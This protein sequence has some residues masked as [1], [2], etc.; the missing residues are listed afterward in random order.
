MVSVLIRWTTAF[1][2]IAAPTLVLQNEPSHFHSQ[3][4]PSYFYSQSDPHPTLYQSKW[5]FR[6]FLQFIQHRLNCLIFTL[7]LSEYVILLNDDSCCIFSDQVCESTFH[8]LCHSLHSSPFARK[9][10]HSWY[11][12]SHHIGSSRY[13]IKDGGTASS[14]QLSAFG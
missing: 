10:V 12:F 4:D 3:N 13:R 5:L 2:L 14:V 1:H 9:R 11:F 7:W 8:A 6:I